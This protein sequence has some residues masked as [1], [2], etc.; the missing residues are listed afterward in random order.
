MTL[1]NVRGFIQLLF[2]SGRKSHWSLP[3]RGR[4]AVVSPSTSYAGEKKMILRDRWFVLSAC[5]ALSCGVIGMSEIYQSED[6]LDDWHG[7][8]WLLAGM[9]W[10][11]VTFLKTGNPSSK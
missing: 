10:L 9:A 11:L 8:A 7:P 3:E 4:L 5:V 2:T 1:R 6:M